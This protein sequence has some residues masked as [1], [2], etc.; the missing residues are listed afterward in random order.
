MIFDPGATTGFAVL[1]EHGEP[2]FTAALNL[3]ELSRFIMFVV[4]IDAKVVVEQGPEWGHHSLITR[5]AERLILDMFPDA[6][7]VLPSQWK[8]HPVSRKRVTNL[9]RLATVH[10][11]D[12]VRLGKWFTI[13]GG[14]HGSQATKGSHTT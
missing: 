5:R 4:T 11:R 9:R 6:H 7:R 3:E 10:E 2:L 12:A 1:D 8:S 13:T 14:T